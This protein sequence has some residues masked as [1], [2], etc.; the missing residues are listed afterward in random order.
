[1]IADPRPLA[2]PRLSCEARRV[3]NPWPSWT[4]F[5]RNATPPTWIAPLID[6]V[7]GAQPAISTVEPGTRATSDQVLAALAP[8]LQTLGFQVETSKS[9]DAKVARPVLF[10][11]NGVPTV[12][13]EVDGVH[14][15]LGIVLEVE[16]GRGAQ[17]N[18]A[19]RDVIRAS[20]IVNAQ[21]L[22]LLM[23][24]FYRFGGKD[25]GRAQEVAAYADARAML[26]AVYAS[27]R[28]LL[29]F[30]GVLLVGY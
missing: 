18:A 4:Y 28:L 10:G 23:P 25:G 5:P 17:N 7:L 13:Y 20:L 24:L 1:M 19:Y 14:D 11:E 16:A 29:P 9:R 15:E 12:T 3:L 21:Y 2:S 8:G 30:T 27:R 6:V 22:V 26:E